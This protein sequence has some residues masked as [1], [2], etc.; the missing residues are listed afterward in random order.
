MTLLVPLA[1]ALLPGAAPAAAFPQQ[2]G[3]GPVAAAPG[4][5]PPAPIELALWPEGAPGAPAIVL[6]LTSGR[7]RAPHRSSG[8]F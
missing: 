7:P 8:S 1:L 5:A 2:D 3:E 4:V 6:A